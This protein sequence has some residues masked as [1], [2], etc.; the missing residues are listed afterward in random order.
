MGS[1]VQVWRDADIAKSC[2]EGIN[3]TAKPKAILSH[4]YLLSLTFLS[5]ELWGVRQRHQR[6]SRQMQSLLVIALVFAVCAYGFASLFIHPCICETERRRNQRYC[7]INSTILE[8]I[9]TSDGWDIQIAYPT[10][11]S[12][13]SYN[14]SLLGTNSIAIYAMN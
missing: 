13:S 2:A 4:L 1:A 11:G 10:L 8:A 3:I 7:L 6:G 14:G 9:I 12:S 5:S